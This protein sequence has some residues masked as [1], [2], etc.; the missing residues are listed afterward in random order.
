MILRNYDEMCLLYTIKLFGHFMSTSHD[1]ADS[2]RLQQ[3]TILS[4]F[5]VLLWQVHVPFLS[6][7]PPSHSIGSCTWSLRPYV[8]CNRQSCLL[9]ICTTISLML[10]LE[11]ILTLYLRIRNQAFCISIGHRLSLN[12][13]CIQTY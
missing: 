9:S 6:A 4:K 2:L 12:F 5:P 7:V 13:M 1:M 3:L 10:C 11:F 8:Y